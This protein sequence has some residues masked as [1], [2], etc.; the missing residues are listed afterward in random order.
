MPFAYLHFN[1][2]NQGNGIG[3]PCAAY[4]EPGEPMQPTWWEDGRGDMLLTQ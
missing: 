2:L 1:A 3:S 4:R